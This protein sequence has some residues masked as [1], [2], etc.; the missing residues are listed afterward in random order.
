MG[1]KV[2]VPTDVITNGGMMSKLGDNYKLAT[3]RVLNRWATE[4]DKFGRSQQWKIVALEEDKMTGKNSGVTVNFIN[5]VE[6]T[7]DMI[8]RS[9]LTPELFN[10]T[11]TVSG[12]HPIAA[13]PITPHGGK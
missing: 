7:V 4:K 5:E 2:L 6:E 10:Q 13:E 8:E 11:E 1:R 3:E 9:G 12:N